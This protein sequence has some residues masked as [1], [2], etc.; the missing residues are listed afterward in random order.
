VVAQHF[1][2]ALARARGITPGAF[3]FGSKVTTDL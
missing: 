1:T 3:T 2:V